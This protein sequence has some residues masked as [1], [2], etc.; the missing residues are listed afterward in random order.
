MTEDPLCVD[1]VMID[2]EQGDA[3]AQFHFGAILALGM[4]EQGKRQE[5]HWPPKSTN[6][7]DY[8]KAQ[9]ICDYGFDPSFVIRQDYEQA[10]YWYTKSAEKVMRLHSTILVICIIMELVSGKIV[11]RLPIGGKKPPC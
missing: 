6:H 4:G 5:I 10:V 8:A 11:N 7:G 3:E 1:K 2:A 9:Y